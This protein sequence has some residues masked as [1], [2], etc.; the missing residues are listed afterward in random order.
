MVSKCQ[1]GIKDDKSWWGN[2]GNGVKQWKWKQNSE[3]DHNGEKKQHGCQGF[4][5]FLS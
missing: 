2:D 5:S 3:N 4:K 1:N